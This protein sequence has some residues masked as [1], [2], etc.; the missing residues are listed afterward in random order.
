[1]RGK[2]GV[3]FFK[4][5]LTWLWMRACS[6]TQIT[7]NFTFMRYPLMSLPKISKPE[8]KLQENLL[9]LVSEMRLVYKWSNE[10]NN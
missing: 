6:L 7:F 1:M 9:V 10:R 4:K 2:L 5:K 8:E 3:H